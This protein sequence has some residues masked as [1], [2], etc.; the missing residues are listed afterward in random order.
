L[1]T[2]F[3]RKHSMKS[4]AQ[5]EKH[6][7]PQIQPVLGLDLVA[8]DI[9]SGPWAMAMTPIQF[10]KK[11]KLVNIVLLPAEDSLSK[12]PKFTVSLIPERADRV[13]AGQLGRSFQGIERMPEHRRVLFAIFI[14]RGCR[15]TAAAR[16]LVSQLARSAAK[17]KLDCSGADVLLKKHLSNKD[18]QK[19]CQRHAY[20]LTLMAS[21]LVFAR[22]DGVL[23]TADFLWL[24]PMDRRLW[25]TLNDVGRQT[26]NTEAA[27]VYAHWITEKTLQRPL[28]I[29]MVQQATKAL[30]QALKEMLYT[31]DDAEH[32]AILEQ[33][34][35]T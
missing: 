17:G 24:K 28:S 29:P 21:A 31:P 20:E 35:E 19:I 7:W 5:S 9:D 15:D 2:R 33:A 26:P 1:R 27:G 11:F 12:E 30:Q 22:A 10:C 32:Q 3:K 4:L 25:Y 34:K 23:A 6:N 8:M 14:A 18:V 16:A 13:F